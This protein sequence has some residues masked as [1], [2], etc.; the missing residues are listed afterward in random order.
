MPPVTPPADE[1]FTAAFDELAALGD[2]PVPV[3]F[4]KVPDAAAP[5]VAD[6]PV[7][8]P[9]VPAEKPAA[10]VVPAAP[11]VE[12][13]AI[14]PLTDEEKAAAAA[15]AAKTPEQ[16]AAEAEAA[17]VE[18]AAAKAAAATQAEDDRLAKIIKAV[19]GEPEPVKQPDP[20]ATP[21]YSDED[22]KVLTQVETDFPDI[23]RAMTIQARALAGQVISHVFAEMA[24]SLTPRLQ[25]YDE[26]LD[27]YHQQALHSK[28]QDYD[29][30]R[31][32][33]ISWVDKQPPYLQIG[34]KRVITDGTADEVSDLIE[35]FRKD[36][37]VVQTAP[38]A[39]AKPANE[40]STAA[41]K[42]V[43]ALAPVPA[44]RSTAVTAADPSDFDGAF[45]EATRLLEKA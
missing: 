22:L 40:L 38:A 2:K 7:A 25:A 16:I 39:P 33:V 37:G 21:V 35:R 34:M 11:A 23:A 14:E 6:K 29:D 32:K 18:D 17:K 20:V 45:A 9:P 44:K 12:E 26:M 4:G 43:A 3:D 13:T 5:L 1:N 36:T 31:D 27:Q 19:K 30:V 41:K 8:T 42:A 28:V 24:K 10:A 15:T